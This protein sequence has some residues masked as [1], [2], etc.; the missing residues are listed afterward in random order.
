MTYFARA[1][2]MH[3]AAPPMGGGTVF[4]NGGTTRRKNASKPISEASD[5]AATAHGLI[6]HHA[7]H[8]R[9]RGHSRLHLQ[10]RH[11]ECPNEDTVI[12]ETCGT[13][14]G[15]VFEV[16]GQA[17]AALRPYDSVP[18]TAG[19]VATVEPAVGL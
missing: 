19:D 7:R 16:N 8:A 15:G 13:R 12:A 1:A 10:R 6:R 4:A 17:M 3:N 2:A 9:H 14:S 11:A 18:D 5:Q